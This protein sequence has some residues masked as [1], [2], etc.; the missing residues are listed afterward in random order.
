MTTFFAN[1][2]LVGILFEVLRIIRIHIGGSAKTHS[3][4]HDLARYY[5][6]IVPLDIVVQIPTMQRY[7]IHPLDSW[8]PSTISNLGDMPF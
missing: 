7:A 1:A 5:Y 2:P 6:D 8:D 4:S 3:L